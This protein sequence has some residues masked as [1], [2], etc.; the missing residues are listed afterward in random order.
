MGLEDVHPLRP[1]KLATNDADA[2][3]NT[4]PLKRLCC[5]PQEEFK[6]SSLLQNDKNF[7]ERRKE[8]LRIF[9]MKKMVYPL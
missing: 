1:A 3:D 5:R 9:N 8:N 4:I 2:S 7:R 6:T